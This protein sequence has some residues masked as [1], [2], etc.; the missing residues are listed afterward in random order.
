MKNVVSDNI[1]NASSV[2]E[3]KSKHDLESTLFP[4][5]MPLSEQYLKVSDLHQIWVVK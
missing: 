3:L 2:Y 1:I 4:I 5:P